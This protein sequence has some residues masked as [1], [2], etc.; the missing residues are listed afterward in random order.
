[1]LIYEKVKWNYDVLTQG[2]KSYL[3][4]YE[5]FSYWH[6]NKKKAFSPDKLASNEQA[7]TAVVPNVPDAATIY[8]SSACCADPQP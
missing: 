5:C 1:M 2:R 3:K 4:K 7:S 8:Y 6:A